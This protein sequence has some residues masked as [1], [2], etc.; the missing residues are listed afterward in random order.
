[1]CKPNYCP[2]SKTDTISYPPCKKGIQPGICEKLAVSHE[3]GG[4]VR[5]GWL[6]PIDESASRIIAE[7]VIK[8]FII[9]EWLVWQ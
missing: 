7:Q 8:I 2:S 6:T 9:D 3:A 1:M 4:R 5:Y